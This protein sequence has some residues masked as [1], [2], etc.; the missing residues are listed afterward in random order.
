MA[1]HLKIVALRR[2]DVGDI[3]LLQTHVERCAHCWSPV[4]RLG[5]GF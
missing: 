3:D 2:L 5:V 1:N 4:F